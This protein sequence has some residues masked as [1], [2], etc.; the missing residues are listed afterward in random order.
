MDIQELE[1]LITNSVLESKSLEYKEKLNI[2]REAEKREFLADVS[3]FSNTNGGKIIYGISENRNTGVPKE[4]VGIKLE[5]VDTEI[6]RLNNILSMGLEPRIY[7]ISIHS[8]KIN[9]SNYVIT[10]EIPKSWLGP[11]RVIYNKDNN[12]YMRN[13]SGKYK[14]DVSELRV[15]F[16]LSENLTYMI[17]NFRDQRITAILNDET[18]FEM[19]DYQQKTMFHLIPVNAFDTGKKYTFDNLNYFNQLMP[20]TSSGWNNCFNLDGYLTYSLDQKNK[21]YSYSQFY[22]SGIIEA[23]V[24]GFVYDQDKE[25]IFYP[26]SFEAEILRGLYNYKS[27]YENMGISPPYIIFLTFIG[28]K[29]VIVTQDHLFRSSLRTVK[30]HKD[31]VKF[32]EVIWDNL[33]VK[34]ETV[35]KPILDTVWNSGGY[36]GS[37]NYDAE[38]HYRIPNH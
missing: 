29:N 14:L 32:P 5:N 22:K 33:D 7:G 21:C 26:N 27:I 24:C 30:I 1:L 11:H 23:L 17:R 10:I 34:P 18:P 13:S 20:L 36:K 35:L 15:A 19:T 28:F 38:G 12:F 31:I 16:N 2:E 4:I 37:P 8:T 25:R 3:S 9:T 6:Q